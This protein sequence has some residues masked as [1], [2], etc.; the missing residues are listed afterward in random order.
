MPTQKLA[1]THKSILAVT[2]FYTKA[3]FLHRV[4]SGTGAKNRDDGFVRGKIFK[5]KQFQETIVRAIP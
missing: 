2:G 5:K 3:K 1:Y 4:I